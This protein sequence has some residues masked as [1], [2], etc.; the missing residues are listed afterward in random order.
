MSRQTRIPGT[1]DPSRAEIDEAAEALCELHAQKKQI[2][3][4]CDRAEGRLIDLLLAAGLHSYHADHLSP[5]LF[6]R[7]EIG[8]TRAKVERLA[9][10]DTEGVVSEADKAQDAALATLECGE[11]VAAMRDLCPKP[12]SGNDSVTISTPGEKP[13]VLT[14]ETRK[15]LDAKLAGRRKAAE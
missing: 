5:P 13:V 1:S 4:D 15:R 14:A 11:V 2:T 7:V 6:V 9:V 12:G 10:A 8:R 3:T